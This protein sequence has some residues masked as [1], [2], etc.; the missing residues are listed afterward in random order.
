MFIASSTSGFA[1]NSA[2][3][4]SSTWR[5]MKRVMPSS[6]TTGMNSAADMILPCSSL[7][8]SRHSYLTTS[9]VSALTIG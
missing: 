1:R 9:K 4:M 6:S 2:I 5:S 8:R 3:A 7:R